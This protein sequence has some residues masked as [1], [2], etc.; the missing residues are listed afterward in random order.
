MAAETLLYS[1]VDGRV[2][3]HAGFSDSFPLCGYLYK[4]KQKPTL[5]GGAWTKRYFVVERRRSKSGMDWYFSYFK[6]EAKTDNVKEA[7]DSVALQHISHVSL[8]A[9]SGRLGLYT[10]TSSLMDDRFKKELTANKDLV[11]EVETPARAYFLRAETRHELMRWTSGLQQ[12]SGLIVD[13]PWPADLGPALPIPGQVLQARLLDGSLSPVIAPILRPYFE[14]AP[15]PVVVGRSATVASTVPLPA[16]S[17]P[18][19]SKVETP[20]VVTPGY[21]SP[22]IPARTLGGDAPQSPS[23]TDKMPATAFRTESSEPR[24]RSRSTESQKSTNSQPS[25]AARV[26]TPI[27]SSRA[28]PS[29]VQ[30]PIQSKEVLVIDSIDDDD[31]VIAAPPSSDRKKERSSLQL[32]MSEE[33]L[34][35]ASRRS[36]DSLAASPIHKP[37]APDA[38]TKQGLLEAA[39]ASAA[40]RNSQNSSSAVS[41]AKPSP[42]PTPAPISIHNGN[43]K[44]VGCNVDDF[45][46]D[47]ETAETKGSK[48]SE[49]AGIAAVRSRV[50]VAMP[51]TGAPPPAIARA[52]VAILASPATAPSSWMHSAN[53]DGFTAEADNVRRTECNSAGTDLRSSIAQQQLEN[54]AQA[55]SM[56]GGDRDWDEWDDSDGKA[57]PAPA[58]VP[59]GAVAGNRVVPPPQSAPRSVGPPVGVPVR[60]SAVSL[61]RGSLRNSNPVKP[62]AA[63][64]TRPS[65]PT[66]AADRDFVQSNWDE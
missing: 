39:I 24:I 60:T 12:M 9:A 28:S 65:E 15:N 18:A 43:P 48:P 27:P 10:S 1:M 64:T 46:D 31:R 58:R 63:A 47:T 8:L 40:R 5:L 11:L 38:R 29:I 54:A 49:P 34:V 37:V 19:G 66:I 51:T 2:Q 4:L 55:K 50:Q 56:V 62:A 13:T 44:S 41:S 6:D 35:A 3:T 59:T 22:P 30:P 23:S 7:G 61:V 14:P 26:P 53:D 17:L 52:S 42:S 21:K 36:S 33:V 57:A 32:P 16:G 45:D 25:S 20:V